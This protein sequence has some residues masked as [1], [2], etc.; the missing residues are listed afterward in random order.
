MLGNS[1]G[2]SSLPVVDYERMK[3]LY[4]EVVSDN[5][6]V[7]TWVCVFFIT[8]G[9]LVLIQRFKNKNRSRH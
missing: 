4:P 8:V 6:N 2:A 7:M 9:I 3:R 1:M 5:Y